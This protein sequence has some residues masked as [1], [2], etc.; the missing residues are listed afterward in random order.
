MK[1]KMKMSHP[2][3]G[4]S[5][6][7]KSAFTLIELLVVI[8]IIAIL[9]AML[10]PALSKA[11]L[12]AQAI[13][14]MSNGKQLG[15]GWIMFADDSDNKI[16]NAFSW[17]PGGLNY[18]GSTDNTNTT[19][20]T[21]G[22]LGPY[23]KNIGVYKCPADMSRSRGKTGDPR[24]RSISMS[25]AFSSDP[26]T[27]GHWDSPPW[28]IFMKTSDMTRPGP[29]NTWVVIDENPDSIND[30]AFAV[31]MD[32]AVNGIPVFSATTWQDTPG[33][34]HGGACGFSFAD[35]HSEV[36]KWRDP[37]TLALKTTYIVNNST[38]FS[39]KNSDVTWLQE[40]TT[41]T[42]KTY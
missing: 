27:T 40:R 15:L 10:L 39:S 32:P 20:L 8:A 42:I 7:C 36:H 11:K 21:Q 19:F 28:L 34:L 41:S 25:Q 33:N 9:A 24:V 17:V 5:K 6:N 29:A 35:G 18:S 14:C 2:S 23:I 38:V 30:A 1:M 37:R 12:R 16:A 13:S 22:L 4:R 3:I 26:K 31:A